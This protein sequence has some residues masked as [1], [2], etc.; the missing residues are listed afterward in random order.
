MKKLIFTTLFALLSS[1]VFSQTYNITFSVPKWATQTMGKDWNLQFD[2]VPANS[3]VKVVFDGKKL[4]VI[5]GEKTISE[6]NVSSVKKIDKKKVVYGAEVKT[7]E[8]YILAVQ[9]ENFIE[10]HIIKKTFFEDN[11]HYYMLYSPFAIDGYVYSYDIFQ[12]DVLK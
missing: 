9:K 2:K 12:S 11:T 7:G 3:P 1:I 4:K 8:D 6:N 10:Y 5:A